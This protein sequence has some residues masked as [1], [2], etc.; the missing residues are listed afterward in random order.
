MSTRAGFG[1]ILV[2]IVAVVAGFAL[3]GCAAQVPYCPPFKA[4]LIVDEEDETYLGVFFDPKD[5]LNLA[6]TVKGLSEG[7]CKLAP[8]GTRI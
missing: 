5:A 8:P 1:I 4:K 6:A 2:L 7:K 3:S